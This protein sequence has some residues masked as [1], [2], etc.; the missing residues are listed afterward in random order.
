MLDEFPSSEENKSHMCDF[1]ERV[2]PAAF[3]NST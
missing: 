2:Q 1:S 3:L